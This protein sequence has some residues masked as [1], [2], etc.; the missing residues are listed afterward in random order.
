MRRAR[1]VLRRRRELRRL[2]GG[3]ISFVDSIIGFEVLGCKLTGCML[4]FTAILAEI[5]LSTPL[6]VAAGVEFGLHFM[7][8]ED[9]G[10]R[11]TVNVFGWVTRLFEVFDKVDGEVAE[12]GKIKAV[13]PDH[14]FLRSWVSELSLRI[15]VRFI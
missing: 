2:C 8:R 15:A 10:T 9:N 4:T 12:E 1:C 6:V 3:G 11:F 5:S 7:P 14:R 13:E